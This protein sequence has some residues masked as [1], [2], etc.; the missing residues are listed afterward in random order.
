MLGMNG[1]AHPPGGGRRV[2]HWTRSNAVV[3]R[4]VLVNIN[5]GVEKQA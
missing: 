5:L 3:L 2:S 1:R 4:S